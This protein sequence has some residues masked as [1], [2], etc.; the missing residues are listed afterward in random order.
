MLKHTNPNEEMS[1]RG[2]SYAVGDTVSHLLWRLQ[3]GEM[4]GI[5]PIAVV[6]HIGINDILHA[7]DMKDSESRVSVQGV[8]V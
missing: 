3:N 1:Q 6:V 4:D 7:L 5:N 8:G 2:T